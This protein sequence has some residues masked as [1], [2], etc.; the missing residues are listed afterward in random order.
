MFKNKKFLIG[1]IHLPPLLGIEGFK[2]LNYCINKSLNDL[3][4]LEKA[5][6]DAALLE[7]EN[8]KPH[9]E[10][11]TSAQIACM[12]IIAWEVMKKA[13]IS[14]GVQLLLNDWKSSFDIAKAVGAK[15]TRL[16]VF[17]DKTTCSWC[18]IIPNPQEIIN[19]KN[20]IYK[21]LILYTD[22]QVKYKTMLDKNKTLEQSAKECVEYK[23]DGIIIT[24]AG[25]G[26]ET[27]LEKIKLIK[28]NFPNTKIIVGAGINKSNI[29]EQMTFADGAIV[30]T[31]IKTGEYVD[32][33]KASELVK[34]LI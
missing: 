33:D 28:N 4:A 7:N 26:L 23:S 15:F 25:S 2:D 16:D 5:G 14:I 30:G 8:D 20:K 18:N 6:F 9:T 13:K 12:S 29:K 24:G 22:I 21:D 19:Y 32:F 11:A 17:V 1:M 10:F 27:P 31:S 3:E 34:E